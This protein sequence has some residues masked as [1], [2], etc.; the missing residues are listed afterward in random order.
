MNYH[1]CIR[2]HLVKCCILVYTEFSTYFLTTVIAGFY[3]SSHRDV[4]PHLKSNV[5]LMLGKKQFRI[6]SDCTIALYHNNEYSSLKYTVGYE[7]VLQ[8]L[9]TEKY[10][11][12][13]SY[14]RTLN[15]E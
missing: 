4:L 13:S 1:Q 15:Q 5:N 2:Y 6:S 12:R 10:N 11:D 9:E 7:Q 3:E 8:S 14:C